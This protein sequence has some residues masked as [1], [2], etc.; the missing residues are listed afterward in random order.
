MLQCCS[1][2]AVWEDSF[3]SDITTAAGETQPS[4][5]TESAL[6]GDRGE[7]DLQKISHPWSLIGQFSCTEDSKSAQF[8]QSK[9]ALSRLVGMQLV[10]LVGW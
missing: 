5:H 1:T 10:I 9:K 2:L 8:E 3:S 7:A 6:H 4:M